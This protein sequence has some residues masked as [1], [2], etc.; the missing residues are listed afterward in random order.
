MER[1]DEYWNGLIRQRQR[2]TLDRQIW[3]QQTKAFVKTQNTNSD[4]SLYVVI[5]DR[6][7][8]IS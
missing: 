8:D 2:V 1:R 6:D 5:R 4:C 7:V 3:K